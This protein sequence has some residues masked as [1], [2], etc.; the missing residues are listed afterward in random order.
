VL[1]IDGK[2]LETMIAA[3]TEIAI[4]LIKKLALRLD[5]ADEFVQILLTPDP[6]ARVML[7]LKR[8]ADSLAQQMGRGT[9]DEVK[10]RLTPADLAGEVGVDVARVQEVLRR[11]RRLH[12]VGEAPDGTIVVEDVGRFLE[13]LEF[14]E[15]PRKSRG[16]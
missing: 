15:V 10:T 3:N 1:V 8:L 4:R 13:F 9:G 5:A 2:T 16:R 14:L 7:G 6:E 11:L 12:I